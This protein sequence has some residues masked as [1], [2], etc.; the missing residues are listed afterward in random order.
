MDKKQKIVA[1]LNQNLKELYA[2]A[3]EADQRLEILHKAGQQHFRQIFDDRLFSVKADRFK[4]YTLEV[5]ADVHDFCED[6]QL[7]QQD[8]LQIVSKIQ[9]LHAMFAKLS[10]LDAE[11]NEKH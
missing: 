8:L 11:H 3:T 1:H 9:Q 10:A 5:A 7:N 6:E 2:L 4:A